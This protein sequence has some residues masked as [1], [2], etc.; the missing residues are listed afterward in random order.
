M[1]TL[2]LPKAMVDEMVAHA[3]A[4][5]PNECCGIVAGKD[6]VA[7]KLY[8]TRNAEA[9][10][11]R[12]NIDPRDILRVERELDEQGW[13]VL[14]IYHSHVASEAYPSPTDVRLS[15]WQGSDPPMDLYPGAYYVLVSLKD[16]QNPA[17]RAFRISG[18]EVTEVD[19]VVE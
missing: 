10:P 14:V 16:R 19:L 17:V 11:F 18:G 13:Q 8:R 7:T 3:I 4:E 15:Q 1:M 12:Y 6:G 5:L 2:R 9:S